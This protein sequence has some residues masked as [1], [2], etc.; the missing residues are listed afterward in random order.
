[1]QDRTVHS[2]GILRRCCAYPFCSL[3][4]D[5][6]SRVVAL[7]H[8]SGRR[9]DSRLAYEHRLCTLNNTITI[10]LSHSRGAM[11]VKHI[12][13]RSMWEYVHQDVELTLEELAHVLEYPACLA[14]F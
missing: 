9:Q 1:M 10:C 11:A 13:V 4:R 5:T 6:R 7:D 3:I 2:E 14:L 12:R 8:H